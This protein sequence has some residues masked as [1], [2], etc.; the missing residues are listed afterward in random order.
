VCRDGLVSEMSFSGC[1]LRKVALP[2]GAGDCVEVW[3]HPKVSHLIAGLFRKDHHFVAVVWNRLSLECSFVSVFDDVK[4][5]WSPSGEV[6]AVSSFNRVHI[7]SWKS[8]CWNAKTVPLKLEWQFAGWDMDHLALVH[9][10]MCNRHTVWICGKWLVLDSGVGVQ[11]V[12]CSG[13]NVQCEWKL[14]P[15]SYVVGVSHDGRVCI[16]CA[17]GDVHILQN[18]MTDVIAQEEPV[19]MDDSVIDDVIEKL[20][21]VDLEQFR[22]NPE[23]RKRTGTTAKVSFGTYRD[24]FSRVAKKRLFS[25]EL[26]DN[27]VNEVLRLSKMPVHPSVPRFYGAVVDDEGRLCVLQEDVGGHTLDKL[28]K[29]RGRIA[30]EFERVTWAIHAAMSVE[31]LHH[32]GYVHGDLKPDNVVFDALG[33]SGKVIDFGSLLPE[34]GANVDIRGLYT[35]NLKHRPTQA[36]DVECLLRDVLSPIWKQGAVSGIV[37]AMRK[38]VLTATDVVHWLHAYRVHLLRNSRFWAQVETEPVLLSQHDGEPVW[39]CDKSHVV[40]KLIDGTCMMGSTDPA[41]GRIEFEQRSAD[42]GVVQA[43]GQIPRLADAA[44]ESR[45]P[46]LYGRL[47]VYR[48]NSFAMATE[49]TLSLIAFDNVYLH[50]RDQPEIPAYLQQQWINGPPSENGRDA[51]SWCLNL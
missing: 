48:D 21:P 37:D 6:L 47:L 22:A 19:L 40:I 25:A 14:R 46:T 30:T 49:P 41:N 27:S 26:E 18:M 1:A 13:G 44:A 39:P 12:P 2:A 33:A 45:L 28:L 35:R 10:S 9:K 50:V 5:L 34:C 51:L 29:K 20:E 32:L 16:V 23:R 38:R 11:I 36:D 3:P 17:N 15:D 31:F 4:G 24:K 7:W 42:I 43:E 8:C